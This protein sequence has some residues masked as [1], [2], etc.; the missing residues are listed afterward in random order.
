MRMKYFICSKIL[1]F[2]NRYKK[3]IEKSFEKFSEITFYI[4]KYA[5]HDIFLLLK[6][7]NMEIN[8][9]INNKL[10]SLMIIGII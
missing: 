4:I 9:Q 7:F 8:K 3:R 5:S 2:C 10:S 1:I 6:K